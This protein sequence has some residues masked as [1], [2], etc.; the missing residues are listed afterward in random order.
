MAERA[1]S[2]SSEV[3]KNDLDSQIKLEKTRKKFRRVN[4]NSFAKDPS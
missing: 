2:Y 1:K 3:L 4:S